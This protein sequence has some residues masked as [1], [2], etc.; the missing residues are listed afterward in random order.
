MQNLAS[1]LGGGRTT[2]L[3]LRAPVADDLAALFE[4]HH[5]PATNR[6]NPYGPDGDLA[7]SSARLA[8]WQAHWDEH[9]FGYWTI[10][11]A[12]GADRGPVVGFGGLRHADWLGRPV[13]NL[14]YRFG[15]DSWGRG[16]AKEMAVFAADA[17]A[18]A[19]PDLPVI[20][21]TKEDNIPSQRTALAAGLERRPDLDA[22]DG[23][24]LSVILARGWPAPDLG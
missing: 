7:V 23:T 17:A 21:R 19:A 10:E 3:V 15:P 2:R 8:E 1:L 16:Y 13:L 11:L 4:I 6:Y 14:Y 9:G 18:A 20:A 5:D 24:G 12:E 22:D